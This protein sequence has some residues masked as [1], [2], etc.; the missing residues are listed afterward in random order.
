MTAKNA[1]RYIFLEKC[2]LRYIFKIR[3]K[4]DQILPAQGSQLFFVEITSF[5]LKV[6]EITIS[7][8]TG[9]AKEFH[10]YSWLL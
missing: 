8:L 1:K 7:F 9:L 2:L 5:V 6:L 4:D 3:L 10:L